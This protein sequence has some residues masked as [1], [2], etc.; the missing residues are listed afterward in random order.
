MRI[1]LTPLLVAVLIGNQTA[2]G[3]PQAA[4]TPAAPPAKILRIHVLEGEGAVNSIPAHIAMMPV[5]E[6]RDENERPVEG[7]SVTFS[8]P[9]AGPGGSF[10]GGQFTLVRKTDARGQAAATGFMANSMPGRFV[11]RV[12]VSYLDVT[13]T[14]LINQTNS[15]KMPQ[16]HAKS[17]GKWKW[18]VLSLA[19]AG[20]AGAGI[21]FGTRSSGS[22]PVSIGTGPIVFG[23]PR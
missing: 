15:D 1:F 17:G 5:I 23:S 11:I 16:L 18:I 12:T 3:Q 13:E 9:Q 21:Y 14:A 8:L 19:A 6:V 2:I 10:L 20:G 7:A 22:S 4:T